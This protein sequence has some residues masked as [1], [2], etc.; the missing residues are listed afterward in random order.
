MNLMRR[1]LRTPSRKSGEKVLHATAVLL[2]AITWTAC[3]PSQSPPPPAN[4]GVAAQTQVNYWEK[5]VSQ[6]AWAGGNTWSLN[7]RGQGFAKNSPVSITS[8]NVPGQQ[9]QYT[10]GT[11]TT[12]SNGSFYFAT[13]SGSFTSDKSYWNTDVHIYAKQASTTWF[14][15][16]EING[17]IFVNCLP[18]PVEPNQEQAFNVT[19]PVPAWSAGQ[20]YSCPQLP[21]PSGGGGGGGGLGGCSGLGAPGCGC[22][23]GGTCDSGLVCAAGS[24]CIACG[25]YGQ[26]CCAGNSC[27]SG[28]SCQFSPAQNSYTCLP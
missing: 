7:L 25:G 5:Q 11:V 15:I 4:I 18:T 27:S 8:G 14:A 28:L 1:A 13:Q 9:G 23:P 22:K 20:S 24:T 3:P 19:L 6:N 17:G 21:P 26:L 2:A 16:A 10:F 12:D